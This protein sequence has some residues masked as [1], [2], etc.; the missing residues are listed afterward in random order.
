MAEIR[1]ANGDTQEDLAKKIKWSRPQISR[2]E[3]RYPPTIE[4]LI[5]F[6]NEYEVTPNE[7]LREEIKLRKVYKKWKK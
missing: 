4:Y 7:I 5:E 3:R 1:K 6:C 2:Y